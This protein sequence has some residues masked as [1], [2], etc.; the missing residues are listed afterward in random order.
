[1][2]SAVNIML[3][4][5]E[6][7]SNSPPEHLEQTW[8]STLLS[9]LKIHQL[10]KN[11]LHQLQLSHSQSH[12][13]FIAGLHHTLTLSRVRRFF[14]HSAESEFSCLAEKVFTPGFHLAVL[15]A[16]ML[17]RPSPQCQG[18]MPNAL[19]ISIRHYGNSHG[20][21]RGVNMAA[22]GELQQPSCVC[23]CG[24]THERQAQHLG[25]SACNPPLPPP[26]LGKPSFVLYMQT[27]FER[28]WPDLLFTLLFFFLHTWRT[29][30][31]NDVF[32]R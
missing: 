4:C 1:M 17:Q 13:N 28:K 15:V 18:E 14:F 25:T 10:L 29:E 12:R 22:K 2:P 23:L 16:N 26:P 24:F 19:G 11:F 27:A 3:L 5:G 7:F 21:D 9:P 31:H 30:V 20:P 8:L 6:Y 32:R